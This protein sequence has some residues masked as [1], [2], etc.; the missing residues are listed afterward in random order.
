MK[1][2]VPRELKNIS[3]L[4]EGDLYIVGGYVRNNILGIKKTDIDLTGSLTPEEVKAKIGHI[5]EIKM[6]YASFGTVLIKA[7]NK[8]YEYTTFRSD[9]YLTDS[10]HPSE[11]NF[12]KDIL[13]DAKRRDFTCNTLYY[14]IDTK[15]VIDLLNGKKDITQK[16]LE[17][18]NGE[19]TFEEDGLRLLRLT[20][21]VSELGFEPSENS[22]KFAKANS[23]KLAGITKERI[24]E[25][26]NKILI[27]DTAYNN[28]GDKKNVFKALD[29][30]KELKLW[31]NVIPEL[32]MGYN[33]EQPLDFHDHDVFYHSLYVCMYAEP[34]IRLAALLHD[35][36]KPKCYNENG[37]FHEHD[38]MGSKMVKEILGQNGL[39]YS[40]KEIDRISRLILFHMKDINGNMKERKLRLFMLHNYDI[41]D[42]L[43]KL[44]IADGKGCKN[45]YHPCTV[46]MKWIKL[47]YTM[48]VEK[49]PFDIKDM[50]I[51]GDEIINIIGDENKV[52][53]SRVLNRLQNYVAA[54]E[55]KNENWELKNM[56]MRCFKEEKNGQ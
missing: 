18:A 28:L 14:K 3:K 44:K 35:I 15:Q 49:V 36:A 2:K 8:T 21:F 17:P 25:E 20:R 27:G 43:I 51:R 32:T 45:D 22:I 11:V 52:M 29:L 37:D 19:I 9:S 34:E 56:V 40:N 12:T 50:D 24:K 1:I 30:M 39:K 55:L 23:D 13:L 26:L 48:R 10:H 38:L 4:L 16:R 41:I 33:Y 54:K 46:V 42:D 7:N 5:Y 31:R 53:T 6:N 47:I